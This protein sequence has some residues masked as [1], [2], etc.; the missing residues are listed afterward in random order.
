MN[1]AAAAS[2]VESIV[3]SKLFHRG[4]IVLI[5]LNAIVVGLEIYPYMQANSGRL[6]DLAD[7]SILY[8]FTLALVLRFFARAWLYFV[9]FILA[10][11]FIALN[12]FV[13]IIVNNLQF[14]TLEENSHLAEIRKSLMQLE[15][16]PH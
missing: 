11:T 15:A 14:V 7:R 8:L 5:F 13:G 10:G 3:E 12:F 9:T 2:R 1:R 6:L 16:R 4:V